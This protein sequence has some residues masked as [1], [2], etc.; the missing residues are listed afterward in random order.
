[1]GERFTAKLQTPQVYRYGVQSFIWGRGYALQACGVHDSRIQ[2]DTQ[3]L[4]RSTD[5]GG[6]EGGSGRM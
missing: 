4:G 5:E 2:G 1:M 6:R 3:A